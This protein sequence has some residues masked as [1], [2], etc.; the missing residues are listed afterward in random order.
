MSLYYEELNVGDE[1]ISPG[2]TIGE[3]DLLNFAG[4]TGDF[5]QL[6]TDEE[7]C[8]KNSMFKTRIAH[9]VLGLAY[10][11]GLLTR[12]DVY[13]TTARAFLGFTRWDFKAPIMIG[14]TIR[15]RLTITGKKELKK[16]GVGMLTQTMAV[17]NQ[18]DEIVQEGDFGM[19]IARKE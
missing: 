14:D 10:G 16:G 19:M 5:H 1:W 9:G 4:L 3:H 15:A 12:V 11:L 2:R 18:R 6:H 13:S 8:K 17:L 7:Y